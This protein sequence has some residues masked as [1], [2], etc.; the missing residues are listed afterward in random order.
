MPKSYGASPAQ[1]NYVFG[2]YNAARGAD[3]PA[4]LDL[5]NTYGK[6][7]SKYEFTDDNPAD[8][9]YRSIPAKNVQN[10]TKGVQRLQKR[11]AAAPFPRCPCGA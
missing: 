6:Y 5:A 9:T 2:V 1:G 10:I 11:E 4:A 8:Q 7:F 3:L